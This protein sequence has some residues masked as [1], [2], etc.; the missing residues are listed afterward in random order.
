[1]TFLTMIYQTPDPDEFG[2]YLAGLIEGAGTF[3]ENSLVIVFKEQDLA[4]A[5]FLQK[6]LGFG[7]V[8]V[9]GTHIVFK[10]EQ[11]PD[12]DR[13][14]SLV[15]GRLVDHRCV[16]QLREYN[17]PVE[18]RIYPPLCEVCLDT[19]WFAGYFDACGDLE[20]MAANLKFSVNLKE[21]GGRTNLNRIAD[22]FNISTF[23]G[24]ESAGSFKLS[25]SQIDKAR[26]LVTYLNVFNLRT[27][28][29][30]QF[31]IFR[32]ATAF[33]EAKHH[34]SKKGL[35]Q[36]AQWKDECNNV[37]P[38]ALPER[39]PIPD[40]LVPTVA[41]KKGLA[42]MAQ[43]KDE[44]NNVAPVALPER[45]PI[46]DILVPTV[47][48]REPMTMSDAHYLAGLIEGSGA[49][50]ATD[51]TIRFQSQDIE[52]A[53]ALKNLLNFGEVKVY[54]NEVIFQVTDPKGLAHIIGLVNGKFIGDRCISQLREHCYDSLYKVTLLPALGKVSLGNAWLSGFLDVK[55]VFSI[56]IPTTTPSQTRKR[57][58]YLKFM[59]FERARSG[60][61]SK[62]NSLRLIGE[63]FRINETKSS[64]NYESYSVDIVGQARIKTVFSYLDKFPLKSRKAMQLKI[65][66]DCAALIEAKK[67][68]S[69]RGL[70]QMELARQKLAAIYE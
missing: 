30:T 7:L 24:N 32:N 52:Q 70:D 54:R 20:V 56:W 27:S 51:L 58:P 28:K 1:M 10:V 57:V 19:A 62:L 65:M 3:A 68:M 15:N 21:P 14:L 5:Y 34:L 8:L 17:W 31:Q 33:V 61:I 26:L 64:F 25:S 44:C 50:T 16:L 49:F 39:P 18:I 12:L 53:E 9:S 37:A 22:V 4:L 55:V 6:K 11:P 43:W 67:H 66:R 13:V 46:P 60:P 23:E 42:Q 35:A 38:V 69:P 59:L 47:A 45:P 40:I 41:S 48:E 2:H 29:W 63:V 36:M